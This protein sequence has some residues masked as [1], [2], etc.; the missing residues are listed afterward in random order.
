MSKLTARQERFV[1]EYLLC[2]NATAAARAAGYSAKCAH[3]NGP[4]LLTNACVARAIAQRKAERSRKLEIDADWVLREAV[5]LYQ[6][7][8]QDVRPA[9]SHPWRRQPGA[10]DEEPLFTFNAAVAARTLELIGRH[11]DVS[12][13]EERVR[14]TREHE[15]WAKLQA[16]R[17]RLAGGRHDRND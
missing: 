5:T 3:V 16:G 7:C 2:A 1:E 8:I 15:V 13:F 14:V 11:V 4:R 9:K 10:E 17:A 12:A 6:R